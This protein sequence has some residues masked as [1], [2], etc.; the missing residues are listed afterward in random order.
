[1]HRN[2]K[3][4][5]HAKTLQKHQQTTDGSRSASSQ[6]NGYG[7]CQDVLLPA[8]TTWPRTP[9]CP[10]VCCPIASRNDASEATR[11]SAHTL[12]WPRSMSSTHALVLP[13]SEGPAWRPDTR[14]SRLR[15]HR[16]RRCVAK[17]QCWCSRCTSSIRGKSLFTAGPHYTAALPSRSKILTGKDLFAHC[18]YHQAPQKQA[19]VS[20]CLV[21]VVFFSVLYTCA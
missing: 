16:L 1:M 3:S 5:V 10:Q 12:G 6:K 18:A 11:G 7:S 8:A 14:P 21:H 9:S 19:R 17:D 20:H 13:S 2:N 4:S 15:H